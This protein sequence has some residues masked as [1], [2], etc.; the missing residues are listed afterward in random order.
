MKFDP[1]FIDILIAAAI[2]S[3]AGY[4]GYLR[5][6]EEKKK[7]KINYIPMLLKF[8]EKYQEEQKQYEQKVKQLK[9]MME[10]KEKEYQELKNSL[11][12]YKWTNP[13]KEKLS[14][15]K[16][17]ELESNFIVMFEVLGFEASEPI[18]HKDKHIDLIVEPREFSGDC[19][20][21]ICIDF[22]DFNAIK[23]IDKKY[24]DQ[25]LEGIKKY[26]CDSGWIITNG[27]VP[28]ELEDYIKE[29]GIKVLSKEEIMELFPSLRVVNDYFENRNMFH[30]L[31]LMYNETVDEVVRRKTWL[32]EIDEALEKAYAEKEVNK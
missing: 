13:D 17:T 9:Q 10:E 20:S 27:K 5:Y 26:K 14:K 15:I 22:I 12:R 31:E 2:F 7:E 21:R 11:Y 16:G 28:D 4:Y 32:M 30:N 19:E 25:F 18:I 3:I 1:S 8:K 29:N 23:K 24:I 6:K